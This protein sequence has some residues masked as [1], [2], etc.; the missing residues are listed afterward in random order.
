MSQRSYGFLW[1]LFFASAG[2]LWLG[3]VFTM[4]AVIVFGFIMFGLVFTGMMCVLPGEVSHTAIRHKQPGATKRHE[5]RPSSR[6]ATVSPANMHL[7]VGF[8][9]P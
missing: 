6:A 8:R 9:F 7:P 2:I 1:I 4:T 5:P 3:G